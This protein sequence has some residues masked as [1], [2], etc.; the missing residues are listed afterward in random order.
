MLEQLVVR[1]FA[2]IDDLTVAFGSGLNALTG[3]TG[4]GKSILI[5]ALGAV[6][7]DRT[8][9]D[10]VRTGAQRATID[11]EF[12][13]EGDA[14][15]IIAPLLEEQGIELH[16]GQ[17]VLTREIQS[18]GR[19]S[20]RINGRPVT[21]SLLSAVGNAL[22]DIHGQS[23][24]LSLLQKR[25]QRG[26]LDAFGVD[27]GLTLEMAR[28]VGEWRATQ[29]ALKRLSSSARE[30][31]QRVDLLAFQLEEIDFAELRSG[32]DS[33]LEQEFARL[34]QVDKLVSEISMALDSLDPE[35]SSEPGRN[36][37]ALGALRL[38]DRAVA[39]ASGIDRSLEP[40]GSRL[41]DVLYLLD[42]IALE[43]RRYQSDLEANPARLEAVSDR[44]ARIRDLKRKYGADIDEILQYRS[45]IAAELESLKGAEFD[46]EA[47]AARE[48][49]L[50][51]AISQ[52]GVRLTAAR[53]RAAE[54][55]TAAA[56]Q[57][58]RDLRLG[59]ASF[60]VAVRQKGGSDGEGPDG[61]IRDS[62]DESG[63]DDVEF[64]FA[65]NEGEAPRPLARIASGGEMARVMLALKA[66]LAEA[67]AIPTYVF[68]EV[69]VGVGGRSGSVVGE[70]LKGLAR[71][72]QILVISHLPQVAGYA[73][74]HF[75]IRKEVHAGR[76]ISTV[77]ELDESGRIEELA[78]MLDGEPVT[79]AS[80][81]NAIEMLSRMAAEP[82][83]R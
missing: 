10:A 77:D 56:Q 53:E 64:L 11:A 51:D 82:A 3:E 7:G 4:A 78:A 57:T 2:I 81:A 71:R 37:G 65:P 61:D 12:S 74:R 43:L 62:F 72:R 40:L 50:V 58:I 59:R 20:A 75:R 16:D 5:D 42:D 9:S 13:V 66:V 21:A 1:N 52:A 46:V 45:A 35:E 18:S 48:T 15:H 41:R 54:K 73:D 29:A 44:I 83:S 47:L 22:V 34:S 30:T 19:S 68:D 49:A 55:L 69:D 70:K 32:E 36:L 38:A 31:A 24:H 14:L 17:L 39:D 60:Q 76:T 23:E 80:R 6:L 67:D 63:F 27:P 25:H 79:D 33:A 28:L 26:I 8:S